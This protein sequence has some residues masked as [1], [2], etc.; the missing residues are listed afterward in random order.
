[1]D[2]YNKGP[3]APTLPPSPVE[4]ELGQ[5][6]NSIQQIKEKCKAFHKQLQ[7][8]SEP[9]F[10]AQLLEPETSQATRTRGPNAKF[11]MSNKLSQLGEA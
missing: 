2:S 8:A 1:M 10:L 4:K 6:A 3:S 5:F 9:I 7:A 11:G